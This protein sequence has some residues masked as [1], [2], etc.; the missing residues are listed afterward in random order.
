MDR[1]GIGSTSRQL[2]HL[3]RAGHRSAEVAAGATENQLG[4]MLRCPRPAGA[5]VV[6]FRAVTPIPHA[7][8][9][10]LSGQRMG[11]GFHVPGRRLTA[12]AG[13]PAVTSGGGQLLQPGCAAFHGQEGHPTGQRGRRPQT[14][15]R[16]RSQDSQQ[17]GPRQAPAG[18]E[19]HQTLRQGVRRTGAARRA[20]ITRPNTSVSIAAPTTPT[21]RWIGDRYAKPLPTC[22]SAPKS[23]TP[24]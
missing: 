19:F 23:L 17:R 8:F 20:E 10:D 6:G 21:P 9:L 13:S 15:S 18:A 24:P 12:P 7:I 22:L 2:L 5:S 1:A 16:Q 11:Y 4:A 3:G 14:A